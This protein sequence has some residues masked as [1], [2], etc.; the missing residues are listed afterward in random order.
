MKSTLFLL[1]ALSTTASAATVTVTITGTTGEIRVGEGP[2]FGHASY[3]LI[4]AGEP[5]VLTYTFEEDKGKETISNVQNGLIT[6]S[7]IQNV[8]GSSPGVSATLQIG[9]DVW[10]FGS[11]S[12]S[13]VL[14]KTSGNDKSAEFTFVTPAGGNRVSAKIVPGKGSYWPKNGDWRS[15]FTTGPLDGSTASFSE[16]NDRVSAHGTLIP[17]AITVSGVDIDGQWLKATTEGERKW[18]LGHASPKGGYIVEQV[19]RTILGSR[20]DGS[21]I[22]PSSVT[23]W[24]A[25]QVPPGADTPRD[26]LANFPDTALAGGKGEETISAVA[27]FYEGLTLPPSFAAGNSSYADER[28]SSTTD[29]HLSTRDATL[30]VIVNTKQQF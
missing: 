29:P 2:I 25:W 21:A 23:Y 7:E 3:Q 19:T 5:F 15:S 9:S 18:Q 26:P 6:Q 22:T 30:P 17:A 8:P 1:L 14:L 10:E 28:L 12:R 24:Q 16:D 11:S 20:A 27:R 13:Q 4:P